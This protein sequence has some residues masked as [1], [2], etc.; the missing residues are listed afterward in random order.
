MLSCHCC[1]ALHTP[2]FHPCRASSEACGSERE[3]KP[4]TGETSAY[5]VQY[6]EGRI[7]LYDSNLIFVIHCM[8]A[9]L[10]IRRVKLQE[11]P[12]RTQ[13]STIQWKGSDVIG[14]SHKKSNMYSTK[15]KHNTQQHL[16]IHF[17]KIILILAKKT[18]YPEKK[19]HLCTLKRHFYPKNFV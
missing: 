7:T 12:R 13:H 16:W 17:Q 10:R 14:L 2:M 19:T 6:N 3:K 1:S 11:L 15:Y 18:R 9:L 8:Y 4:N 5:E